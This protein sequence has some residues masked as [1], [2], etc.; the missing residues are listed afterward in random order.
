MPVRPER[1]IPP[2]PMPLVD[3]LGEIEATPCRFTGDTFGDPEPE[4]AASLRINL[5]MSVPNNFRA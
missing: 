2:R 4:T 3:V 1:V 5:S